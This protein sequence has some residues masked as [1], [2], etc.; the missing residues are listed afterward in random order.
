MAPLPAWQGLDF[1]L[2][3]LGL[4][5]CAA[6]AAGGALALRL[7]GRIHLI[8]GFSAGA[9]IGVA[10]FDLL[11]EALTSGTA[12]P[13]P[14]TAVMGAA[15][16][17]YLAIDRV[18]GLAAG[19]TAHRGHL[20]AGSLV[21]HSV[22]DGLAIGL[23]FQASARTAAIVTV[24]V[25]AHDLC[26]GVNTVN[27]SLTGTPDRR[28]AR[29]WLAADAIAPLVGIGLSTLVRLPAADLGPVLAAFAGFFLYIGASEL[30]PASHRRH[31]VAW[32]TAATLLGAALIWLVARAGG[33]SS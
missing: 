8:L 28:I 26:D 30:V 29:R 15:F 5:A 24:A 17:A 23:A 4:A 1:T 21:L 11:P 6:T 2:P 7:A 27:L 13:A 33:L 31:P 12:R 32:T 9:V 22:M 25:L 18:I 19:G 20:G 14:L 3:A 10:L 16:M